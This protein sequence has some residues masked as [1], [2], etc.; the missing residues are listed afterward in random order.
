[1]D[2]E[3]VIE[4]LQKAKMV[5]ET[6]VPMFEQYN[7]PAGID[8]VIALLKQQ[9]TEIEQLNRFINGFSR[10]AIPVVR[11]KDCKR[12]GTYDC[13]VYVG[14]DEMCSEPDDWFC[15]DGERVNT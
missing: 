12:R 1:M 2:S 5:I 6:W 4:C 15:A 7:T 13:P 10:D 11:C 9:G 14:G 3:N 8:D